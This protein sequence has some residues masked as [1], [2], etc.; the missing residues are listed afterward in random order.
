MFVYNCGD[1]SLDIFATSV[2]GIFPFHFGATPALPVSIAPG[3]TQEFQVTFAPT[4]PGDFFVLLEIT[5]NDS[6]QPTRLIPAS[7]TGVNTGL[8]PRLGTN[9]LAFVGFGTVVSG[10]DRTLP[11][12]LFNVGTAPLNI[13]AINQTNGSNDF[14]LSPVPAFPVVIAPGGEFD[15][16]FIF[17]PSGGGPLAADFS[18][19]SD[20]AQSPLTITTYGTGDQASASYWTQLLQLLGLAHPATP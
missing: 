19:V 15:I 11:V 10:K 3:A 12:Q 2:I 6:T 14:S 13:S 20:D 7:G 18:L 17:T 9:P 4:A 16:T 1:A 8:L 5:S